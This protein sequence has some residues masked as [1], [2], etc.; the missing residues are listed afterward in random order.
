[1]NRA[2]TYNVRFRHYSRTKTKN[3]DIGQEEETYTAGSY[4]WGSLD[5][6]DGS[7]VAEFDG[8]QSG[9][10]AE[11][12]LRNLVAVRA[13]DRLIDQEDSETWLVTGVRRGDNETIITAQKWD[14]PRD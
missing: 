3:P 2:G 14:T 12:R 9:A 1:M 5:E 10:T 6:L 7:E 4:Y 11:I 13:T 8:L